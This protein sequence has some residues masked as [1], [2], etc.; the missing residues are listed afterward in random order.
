MTT[1]EKVFNAGEILVT[2][3]TDPGWT[4]LIMNSAGIILEIGGLLKH[5]ALVSREMGK[6]CVVSIENVINL[7]K[8]GD[9][10]ELD[11]DSGIVKI[12]QR[13]IN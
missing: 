7:I 2:Q 1:N 13:N 6:P 5:G 11:A 10:L 12:L 3:S 9:E 4:P 8:D